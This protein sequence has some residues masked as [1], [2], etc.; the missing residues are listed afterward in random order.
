MPV[1]TDFPKGKRH[2]SHR[3]PPE[4]IQRL[5]FAKGISKGEFVAATSF[6]NEML[7]YEYYL[8][9]LKRYCKE[10]GISEVGTHGLR[11]STSE[12]YMH[13]GAT[14]GDLMKLF[15]HSSMDITE[16]YLHGKN[17]NLEKV[18]QVIRLFPECSQNVPKI[19][20]GNSA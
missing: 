5:W 12:V 13:H 11:H 18:A 1:F 20:V 9:T 6:D 4:L 8:E 17:D 19:D 16:R 2:H 10:L 14:E 3:I 7:S 15:A